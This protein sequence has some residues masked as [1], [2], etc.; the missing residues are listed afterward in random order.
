LSGDKY[1]EKIDIW[2]LGATAYELFTS[3]NP[4]N[5]KKKDELKRIIT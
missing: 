3:M 5:I 1:D 4:F 2:A